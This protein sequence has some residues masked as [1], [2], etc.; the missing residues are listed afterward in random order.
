MMFILNSKYVKSLEEVDRYLEVHKAF[1]EKYYKSGHFICSGRKEPR[2]GGIILCRAESR[3]EV[4][5]I[6][7][8]DP[9][10]QE[11][12]SE[13]EIIEFISSKYAEAFEVFV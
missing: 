7:S 10:M 11:G 3:E 8:Q 2:T 5:T 9:F 13:Y 1:L 12:V 6:L 4:E